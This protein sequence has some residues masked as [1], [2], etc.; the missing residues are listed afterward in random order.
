L[1]AVTVDLDAGDDLAAELR[2]PFG[3]RGPDVILDP[4][5]GAPLRAALDV[6]APGARIVQMG[7]SAGPEAQLASAAIRGKQLSILGYSNRA[8]PR[9]VKRRAHLAM[10]D[11]AAAGR[12]RLA[13]TRHPLSAADE[14][15]ETVRRKAREKVVVTP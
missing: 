11:H 13:V 10:L 5:Y 15:F 6:A 2:Q 14:A 4:L 12:L 3:E 7:Q 8:I 9:E 1:G